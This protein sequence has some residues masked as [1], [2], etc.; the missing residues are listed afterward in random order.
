MPE[1]PEVEIM[2]RNLHRWM[3]GQSIADVEVL[4]DKLDA[5]AIRSVVG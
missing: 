3:A 4:D 1:L 2:A 5:E